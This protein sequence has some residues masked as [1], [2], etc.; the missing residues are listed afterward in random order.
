MELP[1]LAGIKGRIGKKGMADSKGKR[2]IKQL[3]KSIKGDCLAVLNAPVQDRIYLY[4]RFFFV[5]ISFLCGYQYLLY[6]C[7][8]IIAGLLTKPGLTDLMGKP[9]GSDFVAFYA[10]SKLALQGDPAGI[11]SIS[12]IHALEKLV[13]GADVGLRPWHYPPSFLIIVLTLALF[14]YVISFAVWIISTLYG[15]LW[16]VRRISP[17]PLTPWLFLAF[18]PALNNLFYGQN[19][20]LSILLLGGGFLLLDYRPFLGGLLFGLLSYKP[21]LAILI[22][23]ALLAGRNWRALF[24]AAISGMSLALIS[25]IV[26]GF[27]PWKAFVNNIPY[28]TGLLKYNVE[29]WSKMPTIFA[30][31]RLMGAGLSMSEVLQVGVALLSMG[32]V[33]WIWWSRMSITL[34]ASSLI[35]TIFLTAPFAFEYDLVLLALPFAWLGWEEVSTGT[36]TG[37]A[38]LAACWMATYL[39]IWFPGLQLSMLYVLAMLGFVIYR[40]LPDRFTFISRSRES[41]PAGPA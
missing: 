6:G 24:G 13:I 23:V 25:L 11:Y 26:F 10:A 1:R 12:K 35:L 21:Q 29:Y 28:V 37:Q 34:R 40:S 41:T 30:A 20:F 2:G 4:G 15:S 22:P 18:P 16:I 19:G 36:R 7:Y 31:A 17:H 3:V 9:I 27:A 14:P 38:I 8:W 32:V 5:F 39:S 33:A